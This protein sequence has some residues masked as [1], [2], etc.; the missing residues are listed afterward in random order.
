MRVRTVVND[1]LDISRSAVER[2]A[3]EGKHFRGRRRL[4]GYEDAVFGIIRVLSTGDEWDRTG[5]CNNER[6]GSPQFRRRA[7]LVVRL[8]VMQ[9]AY[10]SP[11]ISCRS[12]TLT[13]ISFMAAGWGYLQQKIQ[14]KIRNKNDPKCA[15]ERP[16]V[17]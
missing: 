17:L 3:G 11:R 4:I 9:Y 15:V 13:A 2:C 10:V 16:D 12:L 6:E 1:F 7:Y 8:L 14:Q 5:S